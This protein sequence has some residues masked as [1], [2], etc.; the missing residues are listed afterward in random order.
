MSLTN[1]LSSCLLL[2][3]CSDVPCLQWK[4]RYNSEFLIWNIS[5]NDR[6]IVAIWANWNADLI[7]AREF[8]ASV[9]L[10]ESTRWWITGGAGGD[11]N[12][13]RETEIYENGVFRIGPNLPKV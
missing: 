2:Q 1:S 4:R 11:G 10:P 8:A 6:T 3:S 7:V 12:A 13:L 5:L 9:V